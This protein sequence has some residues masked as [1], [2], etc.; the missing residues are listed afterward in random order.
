MLDVSVV[1]KADGEGRK[2]NER[3]EKKMK[4][5]TGKKGRDKRRGRYIK[6]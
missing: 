5:L 3:H 1:L 2:A 6:Q 4:K